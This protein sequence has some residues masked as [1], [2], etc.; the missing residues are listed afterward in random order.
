MDKFTF[1]NDNRTITVYGYL[2][3][4]R[5]YIGKSDCY[6]PAGTGLPA[7]CTHKPAPVAPDG[8]AVVF[9]VERD[10]WDIVEDHRGK[11][12][13]D[14]NTREPHLI[15]E[16][17]ALPAHLTLLQPQSEFDRWQGGVWEKDVEAE[18]HFNQ[19]CIEAKKR[20]LI[21][22]ASQC[23]DVLIDKINLGHSTSPEQ[24]KKRLESWQAYR[25]QLFDISSAQLI[26]DVVWP[27]LPPQ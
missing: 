21:Y 9:D 6:I 1:S 8:M 12:A 24:D 16:P 13:Y 23:I 18:A 20:Q 2:A 26:D 14:T 22:E 27:E 19:Q 25:V 4:T 10:D 11:T 17:G 15:T 5:E 3:D 7:Y